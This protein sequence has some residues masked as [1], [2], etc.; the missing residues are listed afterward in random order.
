MLR[1]GLIPIWIVFLL[2][3]CAPWPA[4]YLKGGAHLLTQDDVTKELG[5]PHLVRKLDAGGSVWLYQY[6]SASAFGSS[7]CTQYILIFDR[8]HVLKESKRQSC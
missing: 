2:V 5:P 1:H 4:K 7:E 6:L 8:E 3:S